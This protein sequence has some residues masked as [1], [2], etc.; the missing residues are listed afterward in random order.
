MDRIEILTIMANEEFLLP[1]YLKHYDFVDRFNVLYDLRSTDRTLD[2]LKA[3]KKVRIFPVG[4]PGGW[5]TMV[6]Q[7]LLEDTYNIL[8]D[9]WVLNIDTDEFAFI[10]TLPTEGKYWRVDFYSVFRH[11]SEGDLDINKTIKEQRCYGFLE[12]KLYSK[13]ILVKSGLDLTWAPGCHFLTNPRIPN[14][15]VPVFCKG[16]HWSNADLSFCLERRI[17]QRKN[18]QSKYNKKMG[19]GIHN[20]NETEETIR[21]FCKLHSNESK[22]W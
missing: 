5:N 19:F 20:F 17:N 6:Q 4:F 21:E 3:N 22:L 13:P 9:C 7:L 12:D 1:F 2:I 14:E 15:K 16:A 8:E 10:D 11:T 18:V